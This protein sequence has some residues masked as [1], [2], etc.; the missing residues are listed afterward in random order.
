MATL[1]KLVKA[2]EALKVFQ[3]G[4][5]AD[6]TTKKKDQPVGK[7]EK[8]SNCNIVADCICAANLRLLADFPKF[9]GIAME[10]FLMLCDDPESDVRMVADE[11]LNRTIK[12]LLE[13]NLGRLQVELYKE[14]KKNGPSRSLR[15]ALWRFADMCHLIRPQKCRPYVVNLLPCVARI[16]RRNEEPVQETLATCM[17]KVCPVL[18]SFTNDS[19]VKVLL[20]SFLP[21]LKSGSAATRRTAASS[22]TLICQYT[23]KPMYFFS[24]LLS[25]LLDMLI[26]IQEDRVTQALLGV[27]LSLRHMIPYLVTGEHSD[28]SLK[29]SFGVMTKEQEVKVN[30]EQLIQIYELTLYYSNHTDHNVVTAALET[31][32]QLLKTP[33]PPLLRVLLLP[34][35][36]NRTTIYQDDMLMPRSRLGSSGRLP[37]VG[38][39]SGLDDEAD[40]RSE[41]STTGSASTNDEPPQLP[42]DTIDM[43]DPFDED[44]PENSGNN[45]SDLTAQD[46]PDIRMPMSESVYSDIQ[47]GEVTDESRL[48]HSSSADTITDKS[49]TSPLHLPKLR[50]GVSQDLLNGNSEMENLDAD[51]SESSQVPS[52][53]QLPLKD[54]AIGTFTSDTD[55]PMVYCIRLLSSRFL[56]TGFKFGMTPDRVVR[57]SAKALALGCIASAVQLYPQVFFLPLYREEASDDPQEISDILLY[58]NHSDPQLKGTAGLLLGNLISSSLIEAKGNYDNWVESLGITTKN[59]IQKMEYLVNQLMSVIED[60]SSVATRLA[61]IALQSCL[62]RLLHSCH[63]DLGLKMILALFKL[64]EN[65]YWLV[66]V[67]LL[68]VLSDLDFKV[69]HYLEEQCVQLRKGDKHYAGLLHVQD[70]VLEDVIIRLLGDEDARV[71]HAAALALKK[72]IPNLFYAVHNPQH[73]PIIAIA[74]AHTDQFLE[75]IL[76]EWSQAPQPLVHG[77]VQPYHFNPY[78]GYNATTEYSLSKVVGMLI[79]RLMQSAAKYETF[80]LCHVLSLLSDEYITTQYSEAW[81]CNKTSLASSPPST[82]TRDRSLSAARKPSR[83]FQSS[84]TSSTSS[85]ITGLMSISLEDAGFA[86]NGLLPM[87][88]S[89]LMSSP[90]SLDMT[91]HQDALNLAGN[92]FAGVCLKCLRSPE[93][94]PAKSPPDTDTQWPSLG[95]RTLVPLADKLLLHLA[96]LLNICSHVIDE[97]H[98]GPQPSK[99]S[100]P[101]LPNAPSLSPIKIKTKGKEADGAGSQ[102]SQGTE[103]KQPG[104]PVRKEKEKDTEEKKHKKDGLGAFHNQPHYMKLYDVLKGAYSNYKISLDLSTTDKFGSLLKVILEVLSQVLEIATLSEIGKHIDE[105]LG[106]LKVTVTLEPTSSVLCVQQLL[107][108]LFGTNLSA[109]WEANQSVTLT[110]KASKN[111]RLTANMKPGLYHSCFTTPYTQFTQSLVSSVFKVASPDPDDTTTL[112]GWLKKRAEKKTPAILKPGS[113]TDKMSIASYIRLFEPLVIKALKQYTITSSLDLQRQVLNLLAQLVQLRVNYCLLDSDQIFI[114]FVIK[115]FE[116]IEEGQIRNSET[117]IPHIFHFLVLLSY[118]RYH[119]KSIIGM[120]KI[121]QLCDGIM[122]SGQQPTTH[123]IPALQPI[124]HDLFVLRNNKSESG[125][126]LD[127]QREVVVSMLLR[128]IQYYQVLEMF[129]IVLHQCHR[130]SEEKWKRL[131]RQVIDMVLPMLANLQINLD[132]QVALDV[133]HRLF[134]AVAPSVFRPVDVILKT[135]LAPLPELSSLGRL[136]RWMCITCSI[137]RVLISQSKEE[138]VLSRLQELGL[139]VNIHSKTLDSHMGRVSEAPPVA[140]KGP[141]HIPPE[142][143]FS[144]FLLQLV[145][146]LAAEIKHWCSSLANG[147]RGCRFLA[148]QTAHLLLYITHMFQ[149]G[150]FR[151]VATATMSLI[152]QQADEAFYPIESINESFHGLSDTY[153]TLML[154]WCNILIQLNYDNQKW[155]SKVMQTPQKYLMASPNRQNSGSFESKTCSVRSCNREVVRRGGLMLFCDYVCENLTDAE[156][157]I[158][159]IINHVSELIEQS[160]EPPV[161]DF[162]SAIHR[163]SSASGLFIQAIHSRCENLSKPSVVKKTLHC[164]EA[165]H[166]SQS[167][168]LLTLLID[169]FLNTHHLAVA[170]LCDMIS[171]RRVEMLLA[172]KI[173]DSSSQLPLEDLEKLLQHMKASGLTK[174][175]ARLA[176]LL[177]KL[178]S[179]MCPESKLTLSPEKTHPLALSHVE[180]KDIIM[181]KEWFL[182]ITRDQ[183][184]SPVPKPREC[185]MLLQRLDYPDILGIIMAKEF[186]LGILEEC[187]ALGVHKTL[188]TVN[189][190][191]DSTPQTLNNFSQEQSLDALL[192]AVQ[193]TLIRHINNVVNMLPIPHQVIVYGDGANAD[194]ERYRDKMEDF[195]TD[196][197]WMDM[198]NQLSMALLRYLISLP[199]FP[200]QST[201]PSES[202]KDFSRFTVLCLEMMTWMLVHEHMPPSDQLQAV[203]ELLAVTLQSPQLSSVIGQIEN[204]SLLCSCIG[205]VHQLVIS[206]VVL[207]GEKLV[208]HIHQDALDEVEGRDDFHHAIQACD[209]TSELVQ[210]LKTHFR[211]HHVHNPKISQFLASPLRNAIIGLARLSLVNSYAR[212]PLFVWK[213]GWHPATDGEMKTGL[214][215][216]PLEY[217]QEKDVLREFIFRAN[218]LGWTSRQQ[219]EETWMSLLGVINPVPLTLEQHPT[220]EEDI[221]RTQCAV[222]AVRCITSL[223]VQS[224]LTPHSGNPCNSLHELRP[225]DKPLAFLMTRCGKKLA[226]IRGMVEREIYAICREKSDIITHHSYTQMGKDSEKLKYLFDDNI[227]RKLGAEGFSLGQIS[228][229]SVWLLVGMLDVNKPEEETIDDSASKLAT[230]T[231]QRSSSLSG[232]DVHSCLQFLLELYSQWLSPGANPKTPLMQLNET[233]K[234]VVALSDLFTEKQQFEWMFDNLLEV[235]RMHPG[236]DE[237]LNQY[238]IVGLC[239]AAAVVGMDQTAL[240]KVVKTVELALRSTHLPSKI[241]ALYG[242]LYLLEAGLSEGTKILLP[243]VTEYL[244]KHLSGSVVPLINSEQHMLVMWATAFYI[245]ENFREEIRETEFH[246]KILQYAFTTAS[247]SEESTPLSIYMTVLRGLERLLLADS[248]T[249]QDADTLIKLSVDR[250]CLTSPQRMLAALG[251]LLTYMYSGKNID[252]WTPTTLLTEPD[253]QNANTPRVHMT[254]DPESLIAAMERVTVLFER[255]RKGFPAEASVIT[256]ILPTFLTDFFPPQ[257]IMNK[258]IGEFLSNQQ[259]HPQLMAKVVFQVFNTLHQQKQHNLVRDWVMLSLSNFTQRTPVSMAIWSL[260]CFFIS[261][262]TNQW[263]RALLPH[264]VERMGKMDLVDRKLFC[265]AAL[266]F[267]GQLGEESQR[268]AFQTTFQGVALPDSPYADLLQCL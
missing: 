7:K 99:T 81:S 188:I 261:A 228:V 257:D 254:Q 182:S 114:G 250:I 178:R 210:C 193:L 73:D 108:S 87:A 46:I 97:Q 35:G 256:R 196:S 159:V 155:W 170:R 103:M 106:F 14:I 150:Q 243:M 86:G 10:T 25:V 80:G 63:C 156:H 92:L 88:I 9:L 265:I 151:R 126:D 30:I 27:F 186:N 227:E 241:S 207:P 206:M 38:D 176:S 225:R 76:M 39:E 3:P 134:E 110:R 131:S 95:D 128:L 249:A 77:L 132:D 12:T 234:S 142:E 230:L 161:Q 20:K 238:L 19:E 5:Q 239:K 116:Y 24:W 152:R 153:P 140:E 23:R 213:M 32:Q 130:E 248:L 164:L 173:E 160:Y 68:D 83:A 2:F 240:E 89:F 216:L 171:C 219:F 72:F 79:A 11:C 174:R 177:N 157:M 33:P 168:T 179:L 158:W 133:L 263:L 221:E 147:N 102:T 36:I 101:S 70:C 78:D 98:P 198:V 15:A 124:V 58:T 208:Y 119:S 232:L 181:N 29:G 57:V 204:S 197:T 74:K 55:K 246:Q 91:A 113:K 52:P 190:V 96:R 252:Q 82:L 165:I 40:Q 53:T 185:A 180:T 1:E 136:Q 22:L 54:A 109:Q 268:R 37:S 125:K 237:L 145:G 105:L 28:E 139:F 202:V 67:E 117:L 93:E 21:N 50:T 13:T 48:S 60:D 209:Q 217:M 149:S 212:T 259:P 65:P 42:D 264:I 18:M 94:V 222:L 214:P 233:V 121:I 8:A 226:I 244:L 194:Q 45:P 111:M 215:P 267:Y 4:H 43:T 154:Q 235:Q 107:K 135:L 192:Q 6:D 31:L 115:Q 138:V 137:V 16:C 184:Y 167:G 26:P 195:F 61:I 255:I 144:R 84:L 17:Q 262:S 236:E 189:K 51:T 118:E 266:D 75:P 90:V 34:G 211:P 163:N 69:I 127:T 253:F 175:H 141:E 183:C 187:V 203:L 247:G 56:L 199:M 200:W 218:T 59:G 223:L 148:Q 71:R 231:K 123:A 104:R 191:R 201:L 120:P 64:K 129:I 85:L 100:L 66:K 205:A 143:V 229:E 47:I 258:V 260:T 245:I 62:R 41:E 112:L 122:A 146:M 172:E 169:K 49:N 220:V 162:I 251:L 166:L 224:S 44:S 242:S